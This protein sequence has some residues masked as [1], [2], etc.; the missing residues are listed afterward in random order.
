MRVFAR[1]DRCAQSAETSS[2][3]SLQIT[4]IARQYDMGSLYRKLLFT[5]SWISEWTLWHLSC[6]RTH[7]QPSFAANVKPNNKQRNLSIHTSTQSMRSC[8]LRMCCAI[9]IVCRAIL[10]SV[11]V[12]LRCGNLNGSPISRVSFSKTIYY[13]HQSIR[14]PHIS[15]K[16]LCSC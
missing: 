11:C 5:F 3:C 7:S 12:W 9:W 16:R 2:V 15:D 6:T 1:A 13:I 14:V 8:A 4:S 10:H